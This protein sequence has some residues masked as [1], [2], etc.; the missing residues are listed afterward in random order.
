MLNV[1]VNRSAEDVQRY[2][3]RELAVTDYLMREPM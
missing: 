2:F 1:R 3:D